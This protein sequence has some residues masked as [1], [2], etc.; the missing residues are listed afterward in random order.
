MLMTHLGPGMLVPSGSKSLAIDIDA[1]TQ[2]LKDEEADSQEY[3]TS[4]DHH[5]ILTA[6]SPSTDRPVNS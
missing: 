4:E 5:Q 6:K 1:L 3:A 2:P